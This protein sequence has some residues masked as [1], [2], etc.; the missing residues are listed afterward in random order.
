[1]SRIAHGGVGDDWRIPDA[2]W[3][4]IESLVRALCM[5]GFSGDGSPES[6]RSYGNKSWLNTTNCVE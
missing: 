3:E 1:M 2:L 4:R 6:S 5:I